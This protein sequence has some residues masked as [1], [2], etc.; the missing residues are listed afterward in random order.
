MRRE[1]KKAIFSGRFDPFHI[2]HAYAIEKSLEIV[3]KVTVYVGG[4]VHDTIKDCASAEQRRRIVQEWIKTKGYGKDTVEVYAGKKKHIDLHK[5]GHNVEICGS[6]IFNFHTNY[7][8]S[9]ISDFIVV[10]R[11]DC[12]IKMDALERFLKN[13]TMALHI[14]PVCKDSFSATHVRHM[15]KLNQSIGSLVPPG[16]E[17]CI[18]EIYK[19]LLASE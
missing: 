15:I 13:G 4:G 3:D 11:K 7:Y 16:L 14:L 18:L 2:G 5:E 19:P 9:L 8:F 1:K 12:K 10:Q 17:K 6:D